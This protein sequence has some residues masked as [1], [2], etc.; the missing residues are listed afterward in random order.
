MP[1]AFLDRQA[2]PGQEDLAGA[3]GRAAAVWSGI[4]EGV[5][6]IVP[7]L[8]GKWSYGGKAYGWSLALKDGKRTVLYLIPGKEQVTAAFALNEK[9]CVEAASGEELPEAVRR[10]VNEARR[11]PEG[12]AVRVEVRTK[13]DVASVLRLAKIKIGS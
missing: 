10:I 12:R 6:A 4:V 3:L 2:P 13:Q 9:A 5:G 1:S 11:Y 7:R 8:S